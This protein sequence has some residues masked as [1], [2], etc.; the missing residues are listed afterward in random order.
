MGLRAPGPVSAEP[1]SRGRLVGLKRT[2]NSRPGRPPPRLRGATQAN[3]GIRSRGP[4]RLGRS[5]A[6]KE[7]LGEEV[8]VSIYWPVS[9]TAEFEEALGLKR[10]GRLDEAVIA[11]EEVLGRSPSNAVALAHLADVQLRRHKM[12]EAAEALDRA[13]AG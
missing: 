2:Q 11:L 4:A 5:T 13:E 10:A 3:P 6:P 1:G 7:R 9:P 8:G 12:T